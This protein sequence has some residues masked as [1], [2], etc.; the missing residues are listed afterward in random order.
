MPQNRPAREPA[1]SAS[2]ATRAEVEAFLS[3]PASHGLPADAAVERIDTH[4]ATVFLAGE[5]AYKMKRPVAYSFLDFTTLAARRDTLRRELALNRRTAPDLYLAVVPLLREA[6]GGLRLGAAEDGEG[7]ASRDEGGREGE[8]AVEWLLVM[9][10]F[11]QA[12]RFDALAEAGALDRELVERLVDRILAFHQ[13]A[14]RK[15]KPFGGAGYLRQVLA[16]NRQDF[17]GLDEVFPAE[18][19]ARYGRDAA[20]AVEAVAAILDARRAGGLV[21]Q[22][23]GDL[24][25]ANIVL[26]GGEPTLFDCIEF[27]DRIANI[28]L[29]Y[30]VAFLFMDL[31]FRSLAELASAAF[32]RYFGRSGQTASLRA[33]PAMLSIRASV[34]AKVTGL[35]LSAQRSEAAQARDRQRALDYLAAAERY[36][37][38]AT[39]RLIVVGGLSGSGKSTLARALAPAFDAPLGA[40]HLRSD[41]MRKRLFGVAP[42]ERLPAEAY[43]RDVTWQVYELLLAEARMALSAGWPVVVDAVFSHPGERRAVQ[44]VA[45]D[46]GLPLEGIWLEA[47][48]DTL[49]GRASGRGRDA[50]DA[51]AEIVERQLALDL[52]EIDWPRL[53][54]GG[55]SDS[56]AAA[57][58]ALLG[59]PSGP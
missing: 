10:R 23:H 22:C 32:S 33:L 43:G 24:H 41:V 13:G 35:G 8:E 51:T 53:P 58:R 59:L 15:G 52:G 40:L 36:L 48:E 44:A 29:L 56:V 54:A 3:D 20:Q 17:E 55:D 6:D 28:D 7:A 14:E 2:E 46:L 42:E 47:P 19:I 5:R 4:V 57:A 1:S 12:D 50:S 25:L 16:E 26:W 37:E 34:R 45:T 9:R 18:R 31:R 30:D 11:D 49:K 21:R 38:P 27:S 39:P